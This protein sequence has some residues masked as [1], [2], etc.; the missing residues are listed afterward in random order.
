MAKSKIVV[1]GASGN[2]GSATVRRLSELYGSEIDIVA[3]VR[4]PKKLGDKFA[5]LKGVRVEAADQ[6]DKIGLQAALKG[7]SAVFL[8]TPGSQD[9]EKLTIQ[10]AD[11]AKAAGVGH[12][13][14]VSVPTV[15]LKDTIFGSQVAPIEAHF[16]TLGVPYTALRL[17]I[18]TDNYWMQVEHIKGHGKFYGPANPDK[19]FSA[20]T[21][22]DIGD[23]AARVLH[24]PAR[25]AGKIYTLASP[26]AS[27]NDHAK[28]FSVALGKPVEYVQVPYEGAKQSFLAKGLPEWQ[29]DGILELYRL[30]DSGDF[31]FKSD[32]QSVTGAKDTTFEEWVKPVAGA[33]K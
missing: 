5:D 4:E 9:R 25:H 1:V 6:G 29:V 12:I 18:F 24:N 31:V 14:F 20:V 32:T 8:V 2:V 19:K 13:V 21:L 17:P 33:F 30:I 10:A 11:A 26:S 22:T 7:A 16:K 27:H 15:H 23:V 3:G 28:A